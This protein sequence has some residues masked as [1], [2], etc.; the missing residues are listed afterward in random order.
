MVGR[1]R[2]IAPDEEEYLRGRHIQSNMFESVKL[3]RHFL[4]N[5]DKVGHFPRWLAVCLP[6]C[7][8]T[9]MP[10]ESMAAARLPL[11]ADK[12]CRELWQ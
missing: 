3:E 1:V 11:L 8:E 6:F 2:H 9:E 10:D 12:I 5:I 7:F 4:L